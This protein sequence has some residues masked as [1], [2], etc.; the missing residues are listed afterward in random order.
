VPMIDVIF[1]VR[2]GPVP[3]D[4]GY[5]LFSALS[6]RWPL[7][8]ERNDLGLFNLAGKRAEGNRLDVSRGQLR[9]RCQAELFGP[10]LEL[11]GAEL[12]VGGSR[13][14][15]GAPLGRPL[16]SP[17]ALAARVVTI[18][19]FM[20]EGPFREAV[21]RQLR[22]MGCEGHVEVGRRRVV[23]IAGDR[24][25]GFQLVVSR[26]SPNHSVRLQEKGLGGRRHMGCGLFLPRIIRE[27]RR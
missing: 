13:I 9:V 5:L 1:P 4:H 11:T 14:A 23:D 21:D 6:R 17:P 8:H 10:L 24:V 7:F 2:G 25:V 20:E 19:G 26:L 22:A 16:L 15:L 27:A 3:L 18:K 12:E